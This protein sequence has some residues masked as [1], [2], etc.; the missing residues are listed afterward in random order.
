MTGA[1]GTFGDR[2]EPMAQAR[3]VATNLR[4]YLAADTNRPVAMADL[5]AA[6]D[7]EY[8]KLGRLAPEPFPAPHGSHPDRDGWV[9]RRH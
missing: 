6:I 3:T 8:R 5:H 2:Y 1:M 9:A 7:G 4:A